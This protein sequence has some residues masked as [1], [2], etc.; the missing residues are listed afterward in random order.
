LASLGRNFGYG[1]PRCASAREG[2]AEAGPARYLRTVHA[3]GR[4]DLERGLVEIGVAPGDILMVHSSF[5]SF[6]GFRGAPT[7]IVRRC[8]MR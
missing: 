8:R 2:V 4:E 7:Q 1:A 5:D 6:V 3:F